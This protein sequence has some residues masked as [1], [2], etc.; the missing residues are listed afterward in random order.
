M[1]TLFFLNKS[2]RAGCAAHAAPAPVKNNAGA[3][4]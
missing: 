2:K 3:R 1:K 4:Y